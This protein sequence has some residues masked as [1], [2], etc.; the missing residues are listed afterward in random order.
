MTRDERSWLDELRNNG[1]TRP[2]T[3]Y[4]RRL[5][6]GCLRQGFCDET[7]DGTGRYWLTDD[8]KSELDR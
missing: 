5:A 8:G 2:S 6:V 1:P 3:I 4:D 7:G